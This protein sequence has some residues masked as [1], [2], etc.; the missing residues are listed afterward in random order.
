MAAERDGNE[1][2]APFPML[3]GRQYRVYQRPC[4]AME[5]LGEHAPHSYRMFETNSIAWC[6]GHGR[7]TTSRLCDKSDPHNDHVWMN[8]WCPGLTDG[9]MLCGATLPHERHLWDELGLTRTLTHWCV[10]AEP[11]AV[12]EQFDKVDGADI[13]WDTDLTTLTPVSASAEPLFGF[14]DENGVSLIEFRIRDGRVEAKY[15]DSDIDEAVRRF[16]A[17]L[18]GAKV[19]DD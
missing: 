16:V 9:D 19:G 14:H 12:T 13:P 6:N 18:R 15:Y 17:H 7:R 5:V 8:Y 2:I 4:S 3:E 11:D 10:G 1:V